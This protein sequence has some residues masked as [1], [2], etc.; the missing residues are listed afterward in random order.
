MIWLLLALVQPIHAE[1]LIADGDRYSIG[2]SGDV[3]DEPWWTEFDDSVLTGLIEEGV[4]NNTDLGAAVGRLEQADGAFWQTRSALFPNLTFDVI[5]SHQPVNPN[6]FLP[7]G[8]SRDATQHTLQAGLRGAYEIDL[9]G[10]NAMSTR[11]SRFDKLAA[12]GDRDATAVAIST[13]VG[14]AYYDLAA[15]RVRASV[16]Q[17]QLQTNRELLELVELR[18]DASSASTVDVLQQR[19]QV[20]ALE[21]SLPSVD[22]SVDL[23]AFRLAVL[24]GRVEVTEAIPTDGIPLVPALPETGVPIDLLDNRPDLRAAAGRSTSA[25]A[26]QTVAWL[27]FLPSFQVSGQL[28]WTSFWWSE[29]TPEFQEAWQLG[30]Q[31]SL[32]IFSGG[33]RAGAVKTAKGAE[34]GASE[35]YRGA[36]LVALQEVEGAL[37]QDR[38]AQARLE[39]STASEE[40]ARSTYERA[41]EQWLEGVTSYLTVFTNLGAWQRAELDL[42]DA[43]RQSV[44]ARIQLHDALGGSWTRD[45]GARKA[46]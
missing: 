32:P 24:L 31:V 8:V 36:V 43:Q 9:F 16:V 38:A 20:A 4:A 6:S 1:E 30:T 22:A 17:S 40:L 44:G 35:G 25:R 33:R 27:G 2:E 42:V 46:R 3:A 21:A 39:A 34:F 19:Q 15:A 11:A 41:R 29:Q 26:R 14:E 23:T 10:R 12:A 13:R 37:L 5:S 28:G 7:P 18:R 45:L